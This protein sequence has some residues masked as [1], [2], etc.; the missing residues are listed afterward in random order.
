MSITIKG[1]T[2]SIGAAFSYVI[3]EGKKVGVAIE[4]GIN[5]V[6]TELDKVAPLVES[7]TKEVAVFVPQAQAA[8]TAEA[9]IVAIADA[10]DAAIVAAG[11]A[12]ANGVTLSLPAELVAIWNSAKAQVLA[13]LPSIAGNTSAV[14]PAPPAAS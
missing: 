13:A 6:D 7:I 11:A 3:T 9:G 5:A 14:T 2:A 10:V 12:A 4:T 8:V 1:I